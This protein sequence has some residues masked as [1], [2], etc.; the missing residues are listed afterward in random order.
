MA[1]GGWLTIN[2]QTGS[3][4]LPKRD[5]DKAQNLYTNC[6]RML[7]NDVVAIGPIMRGLIDKGFL[8]EGVRDFYSR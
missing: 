7:G 8:P 1:M 2:A 3:F 4:D 5:F 6:A